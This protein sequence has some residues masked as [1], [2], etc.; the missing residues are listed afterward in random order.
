MKFKS[1]LREEMSFKDMSYLELWPSFCPAEWNH[2]YNIGRKHHEEQSCEFILNL[3]L[4]FS[5]KGRLNVFLKWSSDIPLN[6]L[7]NFDRV[8]QEEQF[9]LI[10]L[11]LGQWFMGRCGLKY[12]LSGALVALLFGGAKPFMQ[13]GKTASWGIRM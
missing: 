6:S 3:D 2:L 8:Y 13:F 9:C 7:C 4:L 5:R 12:F 1:L 11:N 10:I